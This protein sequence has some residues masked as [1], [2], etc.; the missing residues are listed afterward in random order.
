MVKD[1]TFGRCAL[2]K[3]KNVKLMQSHIVPKAI[4]ERTKTYGNSRFRNFYNPKEIYQN[5]KTKPLLCHDCEE[6]FSWYETKFVN[7]FLDKYLFSPDSTLP[8]ITKDTEFYILTVAW[9]ILYDTL[10]SSNFYMGNDE[11]KYFGEYEHKLGKYLFQRYLEKNPNENDSRIEAYESDTDGE[12]FFEEMIPEMEM[13][14]KSIT[15]E[16]MAEIKS[17]IYKTGDLGFTDEVN[18]LFH[19]I[20][21]GDIFCD[22]TKTKY[23]IISG[24][25]GLI[26]TTVY[27]R[28]RNVLFRCIRK[29]FKNA[30][31]ADVV[32]KKDITEHLVRRLIEIKNDYPK[33]QKKLDEDGFRNKIQKRYEGKQKLK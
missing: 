24:Y 22:S 25:N 21:F 3:K 18:S 31:K 6:F 28:K 4:Y 17:Y 23:Y 33:V 9:R 27:Q 15:P 12:Y 2:C 7:L 8:I 30:L 16:D 14:E 5:G 10:G 20:I 29:L 1:K 11:R 13:W 26:I 32:V 19:S